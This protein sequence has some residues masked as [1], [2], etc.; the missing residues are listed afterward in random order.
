MGQN[1]TVESGYYGGYP[2]GYL[3]RVMSM[4][5]G[6]HQRVLHL[7]SGQLPRGNYE[8]FDINEKNEAEW[9]G[10]A[11]FLSAK[12][13]TDWYNLILADPPYS[14]EDAE[15]YGTPMVSRSKVLRECHKILRPGGWLI[16][17]DQVFPMFSKQQFHLGIC[18]GMVKSTNHRVRCVF[19]FQKKA[20]P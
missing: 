3:E 2:H 18:I 17:L 11:E 10:N 1:Y 8:R 20:N 6:D 7:F 15:H 5:P 12:L 9:H 16:W 19:G 13:N 4:F 14:V